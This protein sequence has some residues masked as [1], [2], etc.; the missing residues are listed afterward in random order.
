M[1]LASIA[2]CFG[3][4]QV[5]LYT[6][7]LVHDFV[8]S[9]LQILLLILASW[10]GHRHPFNKHMSQNG[11]NVFNKKV[12]HVTTELGMTSK[13]YLTCLGRHGICTKQRLLQWVS[14]QC[15]TCIY[16]YYIYLKNLNIK[17]KQYCQPISFCNINHL[18][19]MYKHKRLNLKT[20]L[21]FWKAGPTNVR[22]QHNQRGFLA[23]QRWRPLGLLTA[24]KAPPVKVPLVKSSMGRW[25]VWNSRRLTAA[26]R[27]INMEPK[28]H[29]FRKENDHANTSQDYSSG[30][31][32]TIFPDNSCGHKI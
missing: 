23:F 24:V 11:F 25:G 30:M 20:H 9:C 19:S 15:Q 22:F 16:L 1:K 6:Q 31:V 8:S 3:T 10:L 12:N 2:G 26:P 7:I 5:Y 18:A 21:F 28:N 32:A 17:K 4:L 29:P 27:K 13:Q 14:L